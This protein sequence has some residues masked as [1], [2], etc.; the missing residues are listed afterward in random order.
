M[1]SVARAL[2]AAAC[3]SMGRPAYAQNAADLS[4][5]SLEDLMTVRVERVFGASRRVQPTTEAPSSVTIITAED[6]A[7]H[8]YRTLADVL[9]SVRGLYVTDDRNYSYVGARGFAR[10]GDYNS[11]VLL[12]V[13]GHR[14]ND[15][16]FDQAPIGRELGLD[17]LTFQR[18]EIIRGPAS[19]LYGTSAFFAVINITTM[20]GEDINGVS[21]RGGVGSL[22][23][24]KLSG[25]GGRRFD[26]G[27]DLAVAAGV[28]DLDGY[29]SLYFA[30]FDSPDLNNGRAERLDRESLRTVTGRLSF[31]DLAVTGAYG[32]RDKTVP[33]AA[34]DTLFNN[35]T[36]VTVDERAYVDAAFDRAW[37]GTRY[38]VRGYLDSYQ[39][40]GVY[41][42]EP[43][44]PGGPPSM[45]T[46]YGHGTWW[47]VEGRATRPLP[48]RQ[49]LT[50][51]LEFRDYARQAQGEAFEDDPDASWDADA[52]THVFAAYAQDEL[53]VNDRL[54][55][56][57][58]GRYDAYSGFD[59]FSPRA[60]V[61]VT[62]TPERAFKY[63]FGS[64]FRAPNA[65]ELD[66]LTQGLRNTGLRAETIAT[67][68]FV[69]EEYTGEWMR[70][71]VSAYWSNA[72]NLLSLV[73]DDEGVLSYVNAGRVAARGVEFEGEVRQEGVQWL[74]S[75]AWQR[76]RDRDSREE[77]T[78]SP[79][80]LVKSRVTLMGVTAD[81]ATLGV[82][83]L[84][85]SGRITVARRSVP[86][87]LV[88]NVTYA[89]PINRQ[90]D[91][92]ATMRNVFDVEYSDPASEEHRQ[93]VI[94]Q[95]GRTF[96]LGLRWNWVRT[97]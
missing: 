46:D 47:G 1:R 62:P 11:R 57:V 4:D 95:D 70:T 9:R 38:A 59:R 78:N 55:L 18:V 35:P 23:R 93:D 66:Y 20:R 30:E 91:I 85:T 82:E 80:H 76:A 51:G 65:Y 50:A 19:A 52:S 64:A 25:V 61:V 58:G 14:M 68:E 34:F 6:I 2:L 32:R 60:S 92:T 75:Y 54:L 22:G 13:D 69:W 7:R 37:Q 40:D 71:S 77:L 15:S 88:A 84:A 17:P 94:P 45:S 33:T 26:S 48:G 21:F 44:E 8:G 39:Y 43:E 79:R 72:A 81:A 96:Y 87:H 56:S 41:P 89:H 90:L 3:V 53:R 16:V 5:L 28:E 73:S 63:L 97:P 12:I 10:P 36:F 29:E 83:L 24:S 27:V 86:G 42:Y 74:A 31:R 67:N 49:T